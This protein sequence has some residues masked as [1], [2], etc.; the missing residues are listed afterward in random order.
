MPLLCGKNLEQESIKDV[1]NEMK[2]FMKLGRAKL[3]NIKQSNLA[4][5]LDVNKL[6]T[7]PKKT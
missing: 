2:D 5:Q 6:K 4:K 3:A 1:Q 7:V